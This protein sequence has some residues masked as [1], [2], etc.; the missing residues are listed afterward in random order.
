MNTAFNYADTLTEWRCWAELSESALRQNV[1]A[2]R[3]RIPSNCRLMAVVKSNAYGHGACWVSRVVLEEGAGALA[4]ATLKEALELRENLIQAPILVL[5]GCPPTAAGLMADL[6]I[7][8]TISTLEEAE[9]LNQQA[10]GSGKKV[11]VNVKIDTGMARLGFSGREEDLDKTCLQ[12]QKIYSLNGL[13]CEGIFTHFAT[14]PDPDTRY[15]QI[16]FRRFQ[17]ILDRLREQNI[18]FPFC[19]CANSAA[20]LL[21]PEMALDQVRAGIILLG[22]RDGGLMKADPIHLKPVMTFKARISSIR[23]LGIGE[24]ISYGL[25]Y[26]TTRPTRVGVIE[27]G[28]ADGLHHSLSNRAVFSL[29][30]RAV[31]QIGSICMDRCMIDLTDC[32]EAQIGDTVILFGDDGLDCV[33][34]EEQAQR[35]GTIGYELLCAVS[36]RVP[37]VIVS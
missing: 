32:P 28:Y 5:S 11:S 21:A 14:A 33:P 23:Q 37:R 7:Q 27:C 17:V 9:A 12:I 16:Q 10:L 1:Q 31:R 34:V 6:N 8:A 22:G 19:H 26:H 24:G 35:A 3:K 30:G 4:V 36:E 2:V 15:R 18:Q 20:T 13:G 25:T 29:R